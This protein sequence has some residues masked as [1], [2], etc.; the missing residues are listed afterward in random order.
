MMIVP[1]VIPKS[2]EEL[3]VVAKRVQFFSRELQIDVV[4]GVF[5]PNTSWPYGEGEKKGNPNGVL[6][7][8]CR[9]LSLLKKT[10]NS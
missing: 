3:F 9:V 10:Q 6:N 4:D 2:L 7:S 1:A 8:E 5:V